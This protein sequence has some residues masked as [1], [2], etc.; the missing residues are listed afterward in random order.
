M[1][2]VNIVSLFL[3]FMPLYL[4]VD[5][6]VGVDAGYFHIRVLPV[7]DVEELMR[8]RLHQLVD[9]VEVEDDFRFTLKIDGEPPGCGTGDQNGTSPA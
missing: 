8:E 6:F 3:V 7:P 9:A 5:L 2:V 4:P 1:T